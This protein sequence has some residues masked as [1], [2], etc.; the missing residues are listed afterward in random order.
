[1]CTGHSF[2]ASTIIHYHWWTANARAS[3]L[4]RRRL[5]G[6]FPVGCLALALA[7]AFLM[8]PRARPVPCAPLELV[9]LLLRTLSSPFPNRD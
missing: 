8:Y 7:L 1:M 6:F 5:L 2:P 9:V 3:W 4:R